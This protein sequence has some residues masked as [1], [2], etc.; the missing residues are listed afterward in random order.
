MT[1]QQRTLVQRSFEKVAPIGDTAARL[2]YERL[3]ELD[4]NLRALFSKDISEQGR[5][6]MQ[7]L[8]YCVRGLDDWDALV[9]AVRELGVRHIE[10]RVADEDYDTVAEALL[11]TLEKGLGSDFTPEVR[12]AW[13]TVYC[14]LADVMKR[15]GTLH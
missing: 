6:L 13:R 15:P 14:L 10:Y 2:F 1:P 5:K 3:F 7:M 11:W 9:P 12:D 8:A 4:P